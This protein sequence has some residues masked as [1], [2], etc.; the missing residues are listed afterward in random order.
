MSDEKKSKAKKSDPSVK[1]SP[2]VAAAVARPIA[3]G[4]LAREEI[5]GFE[6]VVI[7]L[8][9]HIVNVPYA[10]VQPRGA[11]ARGKPKQSEVF[12]TP[13]L[14]NM[15]PAD[16]VTVIHPDPKLPP[17][18]RARLRDTIRDSVTGMEGVVIS[19]T[20]W[21]GGCVRVSAQPEILVKGAPAPM[22]G[23]D[24]NDAVILK[25]GPT[26]KEDPEVAA[27]REL[28]KKGGPRDA[29]TRGFGR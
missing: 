22:F 14:I 18:K 27:E 21:H 3:L 15:G 24:E 12:D 28:R 6:G 25:K 5:T 26:W 17:E 1:A 10:T 4:D 11:D 9:T 19:R 23:C 7:A 8:T 16:G 29:P 20:V 2:S 13:R